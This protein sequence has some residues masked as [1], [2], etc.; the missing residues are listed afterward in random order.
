LV[1]TDL[2]FQATRP[3]GPSPGPLSRPWR[4]PLALTAGLLALGLGAC[5]P[6]RVTE[7]T[8]VL[9]DLSAGPQPSA[10]KR[11]TPDPERSR[12]AYTV[13]GRE[14]VGDLYLPGERAKAALVLVPGAAPAGRDD[15]RLVAFAR[16]LARA[17]FA[18]LVPEIANLRAM[19]IGP[20][21]SL[22]IA[23]AVAQLAEGPHGGSAACV[24]I[25]A[26]SYAAGPA[27]LAALRDDTRTSVCFV[28]T[29][30]GYY[31]MTAV[32]TF[33]TTGRYRARPG[34]EWRHLQPNAYGKWLFL[35]N[36]AERIADLK[37]RV[38]LRLLAERKLNDLEADIAD[39]AA[40]LGPEGRAVLE[41]LTNQ[42]PDRVPALIAALPA[43]VR[44]DMAA[45]DLKTQDLSALRAQLILIHGR[46]D[47][48]IPYTES[49][50]LAAAAPPGQSDLYVT[51][52]LTHVDLGP[53][54]LIETLT[55]WRAVYR[56]LQAR[57]EL[58]GR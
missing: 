49:R 22:Q 48:I 39:L 33:F 56:V 2:P 31:D 19:R 23:D 57:D 1:I 37:D 26:L 7:A 40:N 44:Q 24:G 25:F 58:A 10:L 11:S 50:A 47:A 27:V 28:V 17:R 16:T 15:P 43:A 46:D 55:L 8:R 34:A 30:G 3:D 42:D 45:L 35:R 54:D 32:T 6:A 52:S 12:T 36:N 14:H 18:V 38:S 4:A 51:G 29:V 9:E 41:L 53:G 13:A 5:S 21:D 20:G